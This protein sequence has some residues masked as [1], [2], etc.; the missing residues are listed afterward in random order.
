MENQTPFPIKYW[1]EDDKPREK[2]LLKGKS[3]LSDAELLAIIL[4]SGTRNESAVGLSKR[5]L[6]TTDNSLYSLSKLSFQQLCSFNGIGP[7]KAISIIAALELAKRK[8]E[9]SV[10]ELPKIITTKTVFELM[11]PLLGDLP[12]EEF[13]VIYLNNSN[14]VVH[15]A[16][17]SKGGITGTVV[18]VRII[19]KIALEYHALSF[20]LCHNHPSGKLYPSDADLE[21]TNKIKIAAKQLDILLVD[22]MIV[23]ELGYYSFAEDGKL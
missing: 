14:Q 23:C 16:Q 17:I 1:A 13:W 5:I 8:K 15:K 9:E 2:L 18:D 3:S 12:H 7:A 21:I 22:H 10:V 11:H 4:G 6:K 19:L 20:I